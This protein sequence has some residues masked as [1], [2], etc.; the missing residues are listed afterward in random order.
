MISRR[1]ILSRSRDELNFADQYNAYE[2]EEDVWYTKDKLFKVS[3]PTMIC[4]ILLYLLA[5]G[6][7]DFIQIKPK[8]TFSL[9]F[10]FS[11]LVMCTLNEFT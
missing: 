4:V 9:A 11:I 3:V 7:F 10:L 5:I 6:D 8:E 1:R 2:D